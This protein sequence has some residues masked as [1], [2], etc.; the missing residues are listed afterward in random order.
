MALRNLRKGKLCVA[1]ERVLGDGSYKTNM[2]KLQAYQETR[3]GP[4]EAAR[5]IIEVAE[6][7]SGREIVN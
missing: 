4:L 3:D 2:K 7:W 5:S 6:D 1:I